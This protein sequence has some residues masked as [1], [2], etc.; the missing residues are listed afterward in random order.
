MRNGIADVDGVP[1]AVLR[2]FSRR[3]AEIEA[4]LER[5]GASGAAAA[6]VATLATRR[7]KDYRVTPEQLVPEWRE[8]AAQLGLSPEVV[9]SL[10]GRARSEPLRPEVLEEIAEWLAGPQGLT[11]R[12]S[13]FTRRDVIQALCEALPASAGLAVEDVER[14]ADAFLRSDR[15]IVLAVGDARREPGGRLRLRDGRLVATV[16]D[17]RVYSTPEL[18]AKEQAILSR[19]VDGQEIGLGLAANGAVERAIRR[20]PTIAGEQAEM[21]RRLTRDGDAVAVVVG[22]AGTGKTFALA[23]AREAWE[24]SRHTVIG[25]ALAQRAARELQD[26]AGIESETIAGLL[27]RLRRDPAGALPRR[28][29]L[30]VDEAGMVSTRELAEL[31]EHAERAHAK[32]VLVGDHR[33]LAEIDA[34]GAFRA[35]AARLPAIELTE[36][37]RQAAAWERDA[38]ALLRDGRLRRGACAATSGAAGS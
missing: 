5:R 3:R 11:R 36:N 37:R 2:A 19:A 31:L 29:V 35:L 15:V 34:G 14:L 8:R 24:A 17:E 38:L 7:G 13:T 26:G 10:G 33:Q 4:E 12:R 28:A 30:V 25:A 27:A 16:P 22:Q 23:A 20:R 9:R 32:V 21:V 1:P 18:L 6:Q